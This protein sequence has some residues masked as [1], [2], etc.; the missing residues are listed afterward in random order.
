M[1]DSTHWAQ[2]L[3]LVSLLVLVGLRNTGTGSEQWETKAL[4]GSQ[5]GTHIIA[6]HRILN[7]TDKGTIAKLWPRG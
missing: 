6:R 1:R 4:V 5:L 7:L 2:V 3:Q